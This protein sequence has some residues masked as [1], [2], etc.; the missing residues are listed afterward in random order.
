[1]PPATFLGL[2]GVRVWSRRVP[3]NVEDGTP[4]QRANSD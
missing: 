3:E 1:L 2:I 4:A